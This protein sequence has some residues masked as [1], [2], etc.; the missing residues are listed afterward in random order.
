MA[1]KTQ[2]SKQF[3]KELDN[4]KLENLYLFTGE[5][6]GEKDKYIRKII[7]LTFSSEEDKVNSVGR[8]YIESNDKGEFMAAAEFAL[9]QSMFSSERVCII[10]NIDNLKAIAAN[11]RIFLDLVEGLPTTTRLVMTTVKNSAPSFFSSAIIK[12]VKVVQFWRYFDSDIYNY[13]RI[14]IE[15]FGM[16]IEERAL[17]LLIELTGRDIKKVDDA[18]EMIKY[19]GEQGAVTPAIIKNLIQDVK[20]VSVFDF[21]DLLFKKDKQS[22]NLLKKLVDDG[23]ADLLVLSMIT[24]QAEMLEKYYYWTAAGESVDEAMKKSGI[25][26]KNRDKFLQY[27]RFYPAAK[28]AKLFPLLSKTDYRLKSS[29]LSSSLVSNPVFTLV[30][31]MIF[32]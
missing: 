16:K 4:K 9:S 27:T 12:Q 15:K 11:K 28:T 6:E 13:I 23:T 22:L 5:E 29:R 1:E 24:R 2:N 14:S 10:R 17:T 30:T 20:T 8:Y 25:Y 21:V 26:G 32:L 19:S 3:K 31:Q 18:L 7:D